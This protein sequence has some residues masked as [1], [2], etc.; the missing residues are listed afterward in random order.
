MD[1]KIVSGRRI[2][3]VAITTHA[4]RR[5][6]ERAGMNKNTAK[7]VAERAYCTG[8]SFDNASSDI[9]KY[10]SRVYMSHDKIANNIRIYGNIVYIFDNR[11]LITVFQMP[12]ELVKQI[13]D[14]AES[15]DAAGLA[16]DYRAMWRNTYQMYMKAGKF[17]AWCRYFQ[18]KM[19][20]LTN[21]KTH[22]KQY[23]NL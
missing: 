15:I 23:R 12:Q 5:L 1:E 18:V 3:M 2:T 9:R 20:P 19:K 17:F 16:A 6:K 4:Q 10:I 22:I 13:E 8:I 11:T 14:Y 7:K 21:T